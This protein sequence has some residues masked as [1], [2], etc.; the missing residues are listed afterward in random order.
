MKLDQIYFLISPQ[1]GKSF[2][3]LIFCKQLLKSAL[4]FGASKARLNIYFVSRVPDE[5]RRSQRNSIPY[6][7]VKDSKTLSGRNSL[8]K[9]SMTFGSSFSNGSATLQ[10]SEDNRSQVSSKQPEVT[11]SD[12][13]GNAASSVA[14]S[15]FDRESSV[16]SINR[17]FDVP[18]NSDR[19]NSLQHS[20]QR[21]VSSSAWSGN[22]DSFSNSYSDEISSHSSGR[23]SSLSSA[24]RTFDVPNTT[25]N[26]NS[27]TSANR[28]EIKSSAWGGNTDPVSNGKSASQNFDHESSAGSTSRVYDKP[29][30]SMSSGP[31]GSNNQRAIS[32][33]AWGG[34]TTA[35]S[36]RQQSGTQDLD[37]I[38]R[39]GSTTRTKNSQKSTSK[40]ER[41]V[42]ANESEQ[43]NSASR[44]VVGASDWDGNT[45]SFS[46]SSNEYGSG[47]SVQFSDDDNGSSS[48][49]RAGDQ[50]KS[51]SGNQRNDS[52][53]GRRVSASAWNAS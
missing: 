45:D 14:S 52:T 12:F 7:V 31:N 35:S 5:D 10:N 8:N 43:N 41:N 13:K 39:I 9:N 40:S 32:A 22:K 11:I 30:T 2:Q 18:K 23:E 25:A 48:T 19:P 17:T 6:K 28:R 29:K 21:V 27:K 16:S 24:N 46:S 42:S 20:G 36:N 51:T 33:S 3:I 38:S 47:R 44:R 34:N 37:N 4:I 15:S 49:S 53:T 26:S 1:I 50:S